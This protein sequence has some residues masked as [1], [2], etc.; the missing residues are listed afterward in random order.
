MRNHRRPDVPY[1]VGGTYQRMRGQSVPQSE[2]HNGSRDNLNAWRRRNQRQEKI[3]K[4]GAGYSQRNRKGVEQARGKQYFLSK[5][6]FRRA[7]FQRTGAPHRKTADIHNRH[8][9]VYA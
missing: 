9:A 4:H 5:R 1:D 7:D 6:T 2:K 8:K 3:R